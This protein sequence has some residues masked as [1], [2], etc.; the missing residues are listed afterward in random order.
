[1]TR[2]STIRR[3]SDL[4]KPYLTIALTEI[5][6]ET[7]RGAAIA[8]SA[9]ID[10]ML[11]QSIEIRLLPDPDI[12][13]LLFENR[14]ALQDFSYRIQMA[15]ALKICG[16]RAYKDLCSIRDVRNVA[17]HSADAFEFDREEVAAA[18]SRL[19]F[20][21]HIRYGSRAM[22]TTPREI[23]IRCVELLADGLAE[24][25]LQRP[26][27]MKAPTFLLLGPR[28]QPPLQPTSPRKRQRRYAPD[29]REESQNI[30][31]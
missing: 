22:P 2:I 14:G 17:A 26:Q 28:K 29:N 23:F 18:C 11:R 4:S 10:L 27:Q 6:R 5:N 8:G 16:W 20:P 12:R 7:A 15:Y 19:W 25:T 31:G 1:M 3:F 24:D 30:S 21:L 13:A 9:L